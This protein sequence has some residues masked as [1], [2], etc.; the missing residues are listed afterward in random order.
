MHRDLEESKDPKNFK[1]E[2]ALGTQWTQFFLSG[3]CIEKERGEE[4]EFLVSEHLH[5]YNLKV[6]LIF[7]SVQFPGFQGNPTL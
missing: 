6:L 4:K 7:M 5:P 2:V 3:L 1:S